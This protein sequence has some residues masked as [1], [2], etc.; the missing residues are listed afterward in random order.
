MLAEQ[1]LPQDKDHIPTG[2]YHSSLINCGVA[3]AP[4]HFHTSACAFVHAFIHVSVHSFVIHLLFHDL[5]IHSFAFGIIWNH[6][7]M[8]LTR[9]L[10]VL[11]LNQNVKAHVLDIVF[12]KK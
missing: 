5:F 4:P 1:Y 6:C 12:L 2:A 11:A 7:M 10:M 9:R 3:L 8:N